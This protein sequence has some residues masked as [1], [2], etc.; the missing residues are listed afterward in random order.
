MAIDGGR[1]N[2]SGEL[3]DN[4]AA[5][6][7]CN[8]ATPDSRETNKPPKDNNAAIHME[9]VRT[10]HWC[11]SADRARRKSLSPLSGRAAT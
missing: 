8:A 5:A 10:L 4:E 7:S 11:R 1:N 3:N 9:D 6:W 2:G